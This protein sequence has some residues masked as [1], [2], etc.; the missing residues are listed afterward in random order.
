MANYFS[1]HPTVRRRNAREY[2]ASLGFSEV[3][4]S[5]GEKITIPNSYFH[6]PLA[7]RIQVCA[8]NAANRDSETLEWPSQ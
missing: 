5:L 6:L 4:N 3:Y 2:D 1:R 8:F 7:A